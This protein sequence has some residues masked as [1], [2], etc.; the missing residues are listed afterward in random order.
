MNTNRRIA[1]NTLLLYFRMFII[2]GVTFYTTRIVLNVLGVSDYGIYNTVAGV[3]VLFAFLNNA[4]VTTT[5]RFLNFYLGLDDEE[6]AAKCFSMS[7]MVHFAIGLLLAIFAEAVGLWFL[8]YYMSMPP[9]RANAAFW[10]LQLSIVMTFFNV[11][12]SPY[13]ACL[14]AYEKMDFYAYISIL[15][16]ILKL[17]IVYLLA[18]LSSDKLIMY[19]V[20]LCVVS[21]ITMYAYKIY[22]N[23]KYPISRYRRNWDRKMFVEIFQFS[24]YSLL[25]NAANVGTQQGTNM[26]VNVFSGVAANTAVGVS[27]QLSHGI[28]SFI[29]N[30]QIAFNPMIVKTYAKG[31][32]E[33]LKALIFR[34]SK[35]SYYLM[36]V[37]ST[38]VLIYCQ[39]Y[40]NLWLKEVPEY[41]I[42]FCRLIIL[43]LLIDTVAE[44]LW[45]TVQASGNIKTYQIVTSIIILSNLP[46]A[47]VL[48][49]F[50]YS[51][52]SVFLVKVVTNV[53]AY[54]YRLLYGKSIA[55][56]SMALYFE[57]VLQ[58][59]LLITIP[60]LAVAYAVYISHL[61]YIAATL[62]LL[63]ASLAV[64][65]GLGLHRYERQ[66][67]LSSV[68]GKIK[69]LRKHTK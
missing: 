18:L 47:F 51:P 20:L 46:I 38:P 24:G 50:G 37:I 1:K 64:V 10:T 2:M 57:Q 4:M 21:I 41:T 13:N 60:S 16:A 59:V 14:I 33:S 5:Q 29:T 53:I 49:K 40:M 68:A 3:V 12:R 58:P 34:A 11:M 32:F 69:T 30:F 31:D 7:L 8:N 26:I 56:F 35:Y 36:F 48:L 19:G 54:L 28:Y 44:P 27:S 52:V 42:P 63:V 9:D 25:G 23:H 61:H 15:E 62:L 66:F 65:Y 45:K 67:I 55:K 6:S 17:L 22:C 43:S 39:E